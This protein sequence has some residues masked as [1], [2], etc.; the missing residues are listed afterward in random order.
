VPLRGGCDSGFIYV[1]PFFGGGGGAIQLVS[2]SKISIVGVL[3]ANGGINTGGGSGGGILIEAPAIAVSGNVVANGGGGSSGCL[4]LI[5]EEGRLDDMP[6]AGGAPAAGCGKGGDGGARNVGAVGGASVNV[7][8]ENANFARGG[9]GG[10]GVGRIRVNT[11][12]GGLHA[13]GVFS[14]NPSTATVATR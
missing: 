1:G 2:R 6:A 13:T 5:A 4:S 9:Y 11:M 7:L 10:G 3:A 14:P 12:A 8:G